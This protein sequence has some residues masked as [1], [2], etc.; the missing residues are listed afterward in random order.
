MDNIYENENV[1]EIVVTRK[2]KAGPL[3]RKSFPREGRGEG[4]RSNAVPQYL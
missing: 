2:R 4:S 3:K 1:N